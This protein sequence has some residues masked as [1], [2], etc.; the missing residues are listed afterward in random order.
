MKYDIALI[1]LGVMGQNLAR[2]MASKGIKV[3]GWDRHEEKS[4]AFIQ[5]YGNE[6][7]AYCED[8]KTLSQELT[9][10]RK[11]L[12]LVPAGEPVDEVIQN[13][14]PFLEKG[15]IVI[16]AGNSN[17][18][19]TLRRTQELEKEG[20][21][22]VGMGVSGGEEGALRGPS[23]MPGGSPESWEALKPLLEK[24]AAKDFSG[25]P[26]VS[27]MGADGAGHYVKMVHNG[28]EYGVM[29]MIAEAYSLLKNLYQ[30]T[31]PELAKI[32]KKFSVKIFKKN[33]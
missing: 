8:F 26:C 2:N 22:F 9:T 5:K 11:Y 32:F 23:L 25:N 7:L 6:N 29:Q 14:R 3:I 4:Q 31:P 1:G 10:P 28:I 13:L 27:Y 21:N 12:M 20:L 33:Q 17:Y 16:D 18:R 24:I 19:D 15:D 30:L